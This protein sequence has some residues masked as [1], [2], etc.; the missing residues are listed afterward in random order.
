MSTVTAD[1]RTVTGTMQL[2]ID[3]VAKGDTAKLERAFHQDARMYGS[4]D[5]QRFDIPISDMI[6]MAASQPADVDG[7]YRATIRTVEEEK[8][9]AI[10]ILEED[11]FWGALS[12]VDFFSLANIDGSWK[13]VNKTFAHTGG[14]MPTG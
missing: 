14:S 2:Y 13:I 3:G 12:F 7:S 1:N 4:V 5:G 6:A 11:G 9:A 10:A 8:D